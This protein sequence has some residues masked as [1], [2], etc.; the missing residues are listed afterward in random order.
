[1]RT[2]MT[3]YIA[4]AGIFLLG[5]ALNL[6][7][8]QSAFA[9][10]PAAADKPAGPAAQKFTQV[11]TEWSNLSEKAMVIQKK[12]AKTDPKDKKTQ[13]A[14]RKEFKGVIE[15]LST[16]VPQL[17]TAAYAAYA[18]APNA[19]IKVTEVLLAILDDHLRSDRYEKA[20]VLVRLFEKNKCPDK[21]L[22][23]MAGIAMFCTHDFDAAGRYFAQA[24]KD[25]TFSRT[26]YRYM[27]LVEEYKKL[28]AD[29]L[30]IRKKEAAANDLPR[31]KM[32]TSKG[33]IVLE[34][35]ENEAPQAVANFVSL[36]EKGF[37][38]GLLFHRVLPGF[39]AQ[40]GCPDGTGTGGPGYNIYCECHQKNYRRHFRGSLSMAHA[41]RDTG[42]S[43]FF[44]TFIPTAD[45]N[46]RH[47]VFGRVIE[48]M[49]VLEKLERVDPR[50]RT[51]QPDK[52]I[53]ATV[54]RKR[55]HKYEPTKVKPKKEEAKKE[56][57]KR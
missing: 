16:I 28:W 44:L 36:V 9:V 14:L 1:M 46:G 33:V 10:P 3:R 32:E 40:G 6:V 37:Y 8:S 42:G 54:I 19:D 21:R 23:D 11:H 15:K 31:V 29:E 57:S 38:N 2:K 41:G 52:I 22:S 45:L 17:K 7:T 56:P 4:I 43:Q 49:D 30:A 50:F 47:T 18:E 53:K 48:G 24:K 12:F 34:L 20:V 27:T 13:E 35:F 5:C 51:K 26:G 55:N 25:R 39:M